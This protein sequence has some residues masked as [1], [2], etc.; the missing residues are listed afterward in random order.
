MITKSKISSTKGFL[1][2]AVAVVLLGIACGPPPANNVN[3]NSNTAAN[4]AANSDAS[5]DKAAAPAPVKCLAD[6]NTSIFNDLRARYHRTHPLRKQINYI[7]QDCVVELHGWVGQGT[8]PGRYPDIEREQNAIL[9]IRSVGG[10][11]PTG[12]K[13]SKTDVQLPDAQGYCSG[14]TVPCGSF[15]LPNPPGV[16][17][18]EEDTKGG[19]SNGNTAN[20]NGNT[21]SGGNLNRR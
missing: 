14:N 20:T 7:V 8:T 10:I 2:L 16:C 5:R 4:R 1:I 18:I 6:Y 19:N 21:N 17:N 15:C 9:A 12:L 3:V 11:I 13:L